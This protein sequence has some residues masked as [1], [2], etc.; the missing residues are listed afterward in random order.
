MFL[1]GFED[2]PLAMPKRDL[3]QTARTL[4]NKV[5]S[6]ANLLVHGRSVSVLVRERK[7]LRPN[8]GKAARSLKIDLIIIPTHGYRGLCKGPCWAAPRDAV[9][10]L[11]PMSALL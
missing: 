6:E 9:V 7:S 8:R 2:S 1:T 3:A 5:R 11:A 4:L 10:R